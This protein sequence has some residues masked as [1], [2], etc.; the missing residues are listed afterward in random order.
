MHTTTPQ[1]SQSAVAAS[2]KAIRAQLKTWAMTA[3]VSM[4]QATLLGLLDVVCVIGF[5]WGLSHMVSNLFGHEPDVRLILVPIAAVFVSLTAR[6]ALGLIIQKLSQASARDIIQHIR[7]DFMRNALAGQLKAPGLQTRLNALFE[8]T[9]N[10]EAY[11]MRFRQAEFQARLFPLLIIALIAVVSPVSAGIVL[12]TLLPFVA[13][14]ALLGMGSADESRRQLDALSRLSNLFID[15]LSALPL[16]LSFNAGPR[17][18]RYVGRA[19]HEVAERTLKVL[20]LAFVTSAVLEFFSA[21]SV[22]LIAVYCGFYLLGQLPFQVP[23]KLTL[24][25]AFFV[26]ALSPEIYAPMRRLS[27]AYHD[28]QQAMAATQRLLLIE[29]APDATHCVVVTKA[30][31]I[32][33][34]AVTTRFPDDP[35]F[36]IGPISF[37]VEPGKVIALKGPTG[38]GKTTLLR[39]LLGQGLVA[40]GEISID[41]QSLITSED[42]SPH[43]AWV[44]QS[45]V[46]L[47][48]TLRDNLI[49]AN[50][51]AIAQDIERVIELVGLRYLMTTREGG[52]QH[53]LNERGSGLSG[54]ERRRI[55][56]ARAL[57]K[58]APILLMDEPTADLDVA[59]E[60][61]LIRLLPS[62][63]KGRTVIFSSHSEALCAL[64]D[65]VVELAL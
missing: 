13:L 59:S 22:A 46:I 23:E 48:G 62:V 57:L 45:P 47:A 44:S 25:T 32:A 11:Y 14:M 60:A 42:L 2:P 41:N 39:L 33:Y 16:I 7:L 63:F 12:L 58:S 4:R 61:E 50:R 30:P 64:A 52:L 15:R 36:I 56:L 19:A 40:S 17:Q 1:M 43:I 6:A 24:A 31:R 10:L 53:A 49:L 5:A 34:E 20:K 26:L 28:Q 35:D 8:D 65:T 21:L 9:E 51:H 38:S 29:H 55:G 18:I 27:A 37:S 3:G 54:G